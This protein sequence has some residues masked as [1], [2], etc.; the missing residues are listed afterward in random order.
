MTL[1]EEAQQIQD[2]LDI[3]CSENPEEI[4]ERIRA[5]MPYISRTAF[6]LAEA[7]KALRRKK[8][9]EISNTIINIAK[10]QCL[11]A[12]VQNTLID[13]IAEDEAYLVDWLDRL[14]AAATHQVDALRSIL[15]FERENLRI[16]KTGY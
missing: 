5:I 11:S 12:K 6:M 15:S 14:N 3:T 16:T 2:Y 7:K 13:S 4:L 1:Q 8:A 10:E 9:S